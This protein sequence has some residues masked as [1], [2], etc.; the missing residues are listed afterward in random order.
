MISKTIF[1]KHLKI[2]LRLSKEA[3]TYDAE[4]REKSATRLVIFISAVTGLFLIWAIF[5]ELDQVVTAEGKVI[6]QNQLQVIE[7]YEGGR[8]QKI[9]VK[10]GD[11]VKAGQLLI[12]LSPLQQKSEYNQFKENL[13]ILGARMA[14]LKAEYEDKPLQIP[15]EI[16]HQFPSIASSEAALFSER[17]AR[18]RGQLRQKNNDIEIYKSKLTAANNAVTAAKEE[19]SVISS[20]VSKG[21]EAKISETRSQKSMADAITT[22]ASSEQEYAKAREES[23]NFRRDHSATVLEE[24]TRA[25]TEFGQFREKIIVSAD[26]A[27]RTMIRSPID[28]SVNRVLVTTEGGTVK[29]G[30]R[31]VEIVPSDSVVVVEVKVLPA[32]IGFVGPRQDAIVKFTAY[33][34][35]V[36]GSVPGSVTFVG[37]DSITNEKNEVFFP[38]KVSLSGNYL[39]KNDRVYSVIPGMVAQVDIITG[40]RTVFSYIFSP[41]TKVLE[42]SF[43][44]K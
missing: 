26:T 28:G 29:P 8:V 42:T 40:K 39:T 5:A 14:R 35:S 2:F 33:D 4:D 20:L 3:F 12:T 24:L 21:L 11:K 34:F 23:E 9:H 22:V 15:D 13:A 17:I 32:D 41:I 7:H 38:V 30:D 1:K 27:D 44:E 25:K 6:P 43:R 36:F 10:T 18:F 19:L 37:M 31:V 16:R